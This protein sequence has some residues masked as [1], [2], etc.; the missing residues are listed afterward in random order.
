MIIMD[1]FK[2]PIHL[3]RDPFHITVIHVIKTHITHI[4][5]HVGLQTIIGCICVTQ[6][7]QNYA[8]MA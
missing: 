3:F 4:T 6:Q 8:N 1:Q 5:I 7:K 2:H